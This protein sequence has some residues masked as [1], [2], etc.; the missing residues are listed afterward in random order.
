MIFL[1]LKVTQVIPN[2]TIISQIAH[3]NNNNI[4]T[5]FFSILGLK[6]NDE[7]EIKKKKMRDKQKYQGDKKEMIRKK[8][9]I[10]DVK[11]H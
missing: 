10:L 6:N 5:L 7:K 3:K 1:I 2:L 8:R 4:G 9:G 11:V